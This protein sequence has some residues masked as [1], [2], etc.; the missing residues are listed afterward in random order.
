MM[1]R[2]K[3]FEYMIKQKPLLYR[4]Q[5]VFIQ[6]ISNLTDAEQ[7]VKIDKPFSTARH[8][9]VLINELQEINK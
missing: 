1:N 7:W 6:E 9:F 2:L 3:L 4:N 5:Q 8:N